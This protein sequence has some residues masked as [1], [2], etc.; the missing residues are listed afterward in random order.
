MITIKLTADS[1]KN[2]LKAF[3]AF[4]DT[5]TIRKILSDKTKAGELTFCFEAG[6]VP[7]LFDELFKLYTFDGVNVQIDDEDVKAKFKQYLTKA[8]KGL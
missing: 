6:L 8:L 3:G 4:S 1:E 5:V 7:T 2:L